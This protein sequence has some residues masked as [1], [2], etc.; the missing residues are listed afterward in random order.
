VV[1]FLLSRDASYMT[2]QILNVDGG[3]VMW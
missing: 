1:R 3:L 2:G